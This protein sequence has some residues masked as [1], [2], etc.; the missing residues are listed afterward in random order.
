MNYIEKPVV[1]DGTVITG[2]G[3]GCAIPFALEIVGIIKGDD[4][5]DDIKNAMQVYWM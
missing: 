2:R 4:T 1:V 5:R 3:P